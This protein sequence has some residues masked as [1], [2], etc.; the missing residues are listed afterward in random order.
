MYSVA[1]FQDSLFKY[2][3]IDGVGE[4]S[5]VRPQRSVFSESCVLVPQPKIRSGKIYM[6]FA[7][8]RIQRCGP[9]ERRQA[10]FV[11][12]RIQ[13]FDSQIVSRNRVLRVQSYRRII[14]LN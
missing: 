13:I 1:H 7:D 6:N 5:V 10:L 2:V 4:R 9:L 8:A 11:L 14:I 3:L 12:V